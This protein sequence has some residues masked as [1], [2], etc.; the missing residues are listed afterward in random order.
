MESQ[1]ATPSPWMHRVLMALWPAFLIAGVQEALVF[2]VVDPR[3][4]Q[5]FGTTPLDWP[6]QA[7]YTV[8]FL[9][10]WFTTSVATALTQVLLPGLGRAA[11][12]DGER[13]HVAV[14]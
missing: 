3:E 5:W 9:I 4:L 10:F 8:T 1:T 11:E 14:H 6:V 2:V 12:G 13:Q 7:V